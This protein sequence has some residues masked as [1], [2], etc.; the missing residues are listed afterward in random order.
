[1]LSILAYARLYYNDLQRIEL[2]EQQPSTLTFT[3]F[4]NE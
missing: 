3:G 2:R 1:M 4:T